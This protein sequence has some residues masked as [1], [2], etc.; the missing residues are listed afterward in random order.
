MQKLG[1]RKF[2]FAV[3]AFTW[4]SILVCVGVIDQNTYQVMSLAIFSGYLLANVSQ[5][6]VTPTTT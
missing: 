1:G 4:A 5:K 6:A 3:Y 2:L